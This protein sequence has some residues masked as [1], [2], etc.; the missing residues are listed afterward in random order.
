MGATGDTVRLAIAHAAVREGRKVG[1]LDEAVSVAAAAGRLD[2]A[3]LREKATSPEVAAAVEASTAAFHAH[4]IS[5]RP[6]F[7]LQD[8]I[9]DKAV[10]SGLIGLAPLAATIEAMLADTAAYASYRAHYGPPPSA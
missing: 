7:V 2:P 4:Q 9:G 1:R 10:F 5:Q 8:P 3:A 6:A